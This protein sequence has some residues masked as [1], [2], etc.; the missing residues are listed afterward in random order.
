MTKT[1][2][3]FAVLFGSLLAQAKDCVCHTGYSDLIRSHYYEITCEYDEQG[4]PLAPHIYF[5][6]NLLND[7]A[8]G[9]Q[10]GPNLRVLGFSSPASAQD[11]MM[12]AAKANGITC[13]SK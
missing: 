8:K 4:K 12:K 11:N 5:L 2:L 9:Q 3:T 7:G 6:G 13:R 10:F 1:F